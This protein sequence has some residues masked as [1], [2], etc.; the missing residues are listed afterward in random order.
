[1]EKLETGEKARDGTRIAVAE[2]RRKK[3]DGKMR[4]ERT[5]AYVDNGFDEKCGDANF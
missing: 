4:G 2:K 5:C 1:M 3:Q